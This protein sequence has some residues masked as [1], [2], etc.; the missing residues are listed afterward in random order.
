MTHPEVR[1]NYVFSDQTANTSCN[2]Q[3]AQTQTSITPVLPSGAA[4]PI[5]PRDPRARKEEEQAA[6]VPPIP[7]YGAGQKVVWVHSQ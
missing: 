7:G 4:V 2:V 3:P 6:T 5:I 1:L